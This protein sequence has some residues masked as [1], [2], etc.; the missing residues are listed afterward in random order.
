MK[1]IRTLFLVAVMLT[2]VTS[3]ANEKAIETAS[4]G[5]TLFEFSNV[6]KGHQYTIL[7]NQGVE[8]FTETIKRNGT[9]AKRFDF[10]A[11]ND[12]SYTIELEKDFEI[13]VTPFIIQSNNVIFLES[14]E[15]II[16]KP[17]VRFENNQLLISQLSLDK[18]PLEIKLYYN[19][20]RIFKDQLIGDKILTQVIKLSTQER[21]DYHLSMS[22]GG[23][24][25]IK[26]FEL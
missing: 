2:I 3:Y 17:V 8:L 12:G 26:N 24:T 21:G 22:F 19:G 13:V 14:K 16:F 9:F 4:K 18:Q 20:E 11:L 1:T 23:R 5:I 15:K 25:F 10:T 6:K 7:D